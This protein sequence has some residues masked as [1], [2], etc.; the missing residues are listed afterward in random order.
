EPLG[1]FDF[2]IPGLVLASVGLVCVVLIMPRLLRRRRSPT[3]RFMTGNHRRFIAPLT[4]GNE[5]KLVGAAARSDRLGIRGS[6]LLL[7]QRGEHPHTPPLG[8][9]KIREGDVLV[10]MATH[11]ALAEA[12]TK[13]PRLM[14]SVSGRDDLPASDEEREAWLSRGQMVAEVMIAPGSRLAGYSLEEVGFRARYGCLVLGVERRSRLT[15]P[16]VGS[17]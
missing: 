10:V 17:P 4:V 9:L 5:P 1:F 11:D 12:Q 6:R 15:R 3:Q 7:V 14:F 2:A 16:L 8:G 13:F